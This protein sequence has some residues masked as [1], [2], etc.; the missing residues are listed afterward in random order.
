V[1]RFDF[2]APIKTVLCVTCGQPLVA[3][4]DAPEPIR[5]VLCAI[6]ETLTPTPSTAGKPMPSQKHGRSAA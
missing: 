4:L 5:C 3:D 1:S 6:R 2:Q